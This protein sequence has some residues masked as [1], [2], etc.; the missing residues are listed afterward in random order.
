MPQYIRS[1]TPGGTFFFTVGLLE[2]ERGLLVEHIRELR[3][4]FRKVRQRRPFEI[5]A[6]VV[7]PGH[8]HC[9]WTLPPGDTDF[10]TRWRLIK[11]RFA[12]SLPT[13][14]WLSQ[15]RQSKGERGI[16]Q[17]RFWEHTIRDEADYAA[18]V[19]YIHFNPV[20]HGHVIRAADWPHSSIHRYIADGRI[21]AGW[22]AEPDI[23]DRDYE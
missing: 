8:L 15:R 3:E 22:A 12:G 21:D 23:A 13:A 10:S 7:L 1:H 9:I 18:H 19:D 4:A 2:R 20:K 17:R 6:I 5:D 16:W 14:E 11:T